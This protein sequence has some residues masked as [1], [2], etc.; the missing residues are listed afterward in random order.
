MNSLENN[1]DY[2]D[3]KRLLAGY[4]LICLGTI[5]IAAFEAANTSTQGTLT[6][7]A[8]TSPFL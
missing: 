4:M 7:K 2:C 5:N 6:L 8:L 1:A 3:I